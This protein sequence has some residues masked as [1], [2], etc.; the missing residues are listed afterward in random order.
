[1]SVI[2]KVFTEHVF[3]LLHQSIRLSAV[4]EAEHDHWPPLMSVKKSP[5]FSFS[6]LGPTT[7]PPTSLVRILYPTVFWASSVMSIMEPDNPP[8][9]MLKM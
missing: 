9:S 1:M 6:M 2:S 3:R 5:E 8:F 7:V 4:L